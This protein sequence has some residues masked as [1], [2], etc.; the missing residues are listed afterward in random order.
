VLELTPTNGSTFLVFASGRDVI[1]EQDE[2]HNVHG[3]PNIQTALQDLAQ[4]CDAANVDIYTIRVVD[5]RGI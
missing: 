4:R 5:N 1:V 2:T 3:Y